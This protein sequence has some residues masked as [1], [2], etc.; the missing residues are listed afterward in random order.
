M[1]ESKDEQGD[2][3][4]TEKQVVR[5]F[6]G[7]GDLNRDV[8]RQMGFA[9]LKRLGKRVIVCVDSLV[10]V[11]SFADEADKKFYKDLKNKTLPEITKWWENISHEIETMFNES[12]NEYYSIIKEKYKSTPGYEVFVNDRWEAHGNFK[13]FNYIPPFLSEIVNTYGAEVCFIGTSKKIFMRAVTYDFDGNLRQAILY[14][15]MHEYDEVYIKSDIAIGAISIVV[16]SLLGKI[17]KRFMADNIIH[18]LDEDKNSS[19]ILYMLPGEAVGIRSLL[20]DRYLIEEINPTVIA[21][22]AEVIKIIGNAF[23]MLEN[24]LPDDIRMVRKAI[25]EANLDSYLK[26]IDTL[27]RNLLIKVSDEQFLALRRVLFIEDFSKVALRCLNNG[28]TVY[29]IKDIEELIS[30]SKCLG[31]WEGIKKLYMDHHSILK[32]DAMPESYEMFLKS[33]EKIFE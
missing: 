16:S 31:S 27:F 13:A 22:A 21:G 12:Y 4:S 17:S 8:L 10:C 1:E 6:E 9:Q 2:Q 29:D 14:Q 24:L 11:D 19:V 7:Q 26:T 28:L 20:N 33:I 30:R 25:E 23:E 18:I 32:I 3:N 15:Q 5:I